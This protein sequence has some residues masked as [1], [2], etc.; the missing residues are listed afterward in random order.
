MTADELRISDWSS[1][2][3][4]SYLKAGIVLGEAQRLFALVERLGSHNAQGEY[5]LTDIFALA[6]AEGRPA[7]VVE[8][9][10][11]EVLGVNSRADLALVESVMQQ[12]LRRAAMA[13][14]ATL[15]DPA[16]V[17]LSADT[18]LGRDVTVQPSVFFGP[19]VSVGDRVEIRSFCHQIGS[20]SCRERVCRTGR[21]RG[22]PAQ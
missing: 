13:A 14:G 16:T 12:R 11:E 5:Y 3:C 1:D 7:G 10:A 8:C 18:R 17:W 19:G 6:H 22:V 21:S 2:V 9:P 15:I 20:A 4:S